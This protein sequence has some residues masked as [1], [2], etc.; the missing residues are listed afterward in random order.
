MAENNNGASVSDTSNN[1]D[2]PQT[3]SKIETETIDI[4]PFPSGAIELISLFEGTTKVNDFID[5]LESVAKL[6]NLDQSQ[7]KALAILKLRGRAKEFLDT[8]MRIKTEG[9]WDDLKKGLKKRFE[10]QKLPGQVE[11]EFQNCRQRVGESIR[12]FSE[13]VRKLGLLTVTYTDDPQHNIFTTNA[14]TRDFLRIFKTGLLGVVRQRVMSK[15]PQEFEEAIEIAEQEEIIETFTK[16][17]VV[18]EV[19]AAEKNGNSSKGKQKVTRNNENEKKTEKNVNYAEHRT[20]N[21]NRFQGN[22]SQRDGLTSYP[23]N[24]QRNFQQNFQRNHWTAPHFKTNYNSYQSN[25]NPRYS[26]TPTFYGAPRFNGNSGFNGNPR[27]HGNL[28]NGNYHFNAHYYNQ[29]P[30]KQGIRP[31]ANQNNQQQGH[32]GIRC[33]RCN[34]IGH[35]TNNCQTNLEL[36]CFKCGKTGHIARVCRSVQPE[37]QQEE[38]LLNCKKVVSEVRDA[39]KKQ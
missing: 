27:F 36:N 35:L 24:Q 32:R 4:K 2:R 11:H 12:D 39:T 7:C 33:Y 19:N 25:G 22:T 8:H 16:N 10:K 14:L 28:R 3:T 13:R 20:Y 6:M 30:T 18:D 29:Q 38:K 37:P 9:T 26:G 34:N 17:V 21:Q 1:E 23:V 15:N 31:Y 5:N